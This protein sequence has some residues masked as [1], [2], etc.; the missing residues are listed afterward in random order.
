M[1]QYINAIMLGVLKGLLMLTIVVVNYLM[2]K[3]L[4]FQFSDRAEAA[5]EKDVLTVAGKWIAGKAPGWENEIVPANDQWIAAAAA[6]LATR[7]G[8]SPA[9]LQDAIA[10]RIGAYQAQVLAGAAKAAPL[11]LAA[12]VGMLALNALTGCADAA[13]TP[14]QA[15]AARA[16]IHTPKALARAYVATTAAPKA[17]ASTS[18]DPIAVVQQFTVADLQNALADAATPLSPVPAGCTAGL[19]LTATGAACVTDPTAAACYTALI[20]YVQANAVNPLPTKLGAFLAFQKARDLKTLINQGIP[21]GINNACAPLVLD[22][23]NTIVGLAAKIG[24]GAVVGGINLG[25]GALPL[26]L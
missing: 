6:D 13:G 22:A 26:G 12:V 10:A 3:Y 11:L 21:A 15:A 2:A 23:A 1:D 14:V 16:A 4:H 7:N 24:M 18:S 19:L 9:K 17:A 20:P 5:E 25:I 8:A